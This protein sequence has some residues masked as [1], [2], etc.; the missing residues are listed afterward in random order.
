MKTKEEIPLK[1]IKINA[2]CLCFKQAKWLELSAF[3]IALCLQIQSNDI[4][5]LF[6][7]RSFRQISVRNLVQTRLRENVEAWSRYKNTC[8]KLSDREGHGHKAVLYKS[9]FPATKAL[10]YIHSDRDTTVYIG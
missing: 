1:Q 4:Q 3:P 9:Y 2:G 5:W 8:S 6:L 10:Q 7:T